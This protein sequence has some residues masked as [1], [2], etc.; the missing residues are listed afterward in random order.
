MLSVLLLSIDSV[1]LKPNHT[2]IDFTE[3]GIF[4][5]ALGQLIAGVAISTSSTSGPGRGAKEPS[6]RR[7]RRSAG[8]L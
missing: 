5:Y 7:S 2:V 6:W 1:P 3:W 4:V 8:S